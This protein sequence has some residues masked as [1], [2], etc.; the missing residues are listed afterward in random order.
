[1]EDKD[2][3]TI[4]HFCGRHPRNWIETSGEHLILGKKLRDACKVPDDYRTSDE[5]TKETI[6]RKASMA[7]EEGV[8]K[9]G[10]IKEEKTEKK[11]EKKS[12]IK[13]Y[14]ERTKGYMSKDIRNSLNVSSRIT[15]KLEISVEKLVKPTRDFLNGSVTIRRYHLAL[16]PAFLI[17]MYLF[18][19]REKVI[20][21]I[22]RFEEKVIYGIDDMSVKAYYDI[23]N[24]GIKQSHNV[25]KTIKNAYDSSRK[26]V[27]NAW[28]YAVRTSTTAYNGLKEGIK[29]SDLALYYANKGKNSVKKAAEEGKSL[30]N[31][32]IDEKAIETVRK[33]EKSEKK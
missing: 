10:E 26:R 20:R 9:T 29:N 17:G 4:L 23:K 13:E 31:G 32:F 19:N 30:I 2:A 33:D 5:I 1:M 18:G 3:E 6:E 21:P 8:K 12:K 28:K 16:V 11:P 14:F 22:M 15:S 7:K 27:K 24:S 25:N